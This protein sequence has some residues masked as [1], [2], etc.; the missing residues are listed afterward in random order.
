MS[1]IFVFSLCPAPEQKYLLEGSSSTCLMSWILWQVC[2]VCMPRSQTLNTWIWWTSGL[3]FLGLL[4]LLSQRECSVEHCTDGGLKHSPSVSVKEACL[5]ILEFWPKRQA[6]GLTHIKEVYRDALRELKD[7]TF[8]LSLC[9]A[10]ADQ[11]LS[12]RSLSTH[13]GLQIM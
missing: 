6:S 1:T 12:E 11:Y 5:L 7:A 13:L 9:L 8:A 4:G 10:T 3:I 2:L